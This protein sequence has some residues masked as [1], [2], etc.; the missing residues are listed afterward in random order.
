MHTVHKNIIIL[1]FI[2]YKL[3]FRFYLR[4]NFAQK[5][6]KQNVVLNKQVVSFFYIFLNRINYDFVIFFLQNVNIYVKT[7]DFIEINAKS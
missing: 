7:F 1:D 3:I 5:Y 6:N 4:K 2:K